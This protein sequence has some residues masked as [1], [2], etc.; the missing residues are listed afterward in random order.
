MQQKQK[1]NG[2]AWNTQQQQQKK[3]CSRAKKTILKTSKYKTAAKELEMHYTNP[4]NNTDTRMPCTQDC[5][6][7]L[8][9]S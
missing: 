2:K 6:P 8:N 7:S 4:H 3:L 1:N 9:D 5:L